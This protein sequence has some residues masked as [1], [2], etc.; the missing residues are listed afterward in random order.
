M[1]Y[2][3]DNK[4]VVAVASS[5]L[6]DLSESHAI[7]EKEGLQ[8]YRAHQQEHQEKPFRPGI[9]FPFIRRLLSLNQ[10]NPVDPPVEVVF[11]SR[12]DPDTGLRVLKSTA[13][14]SLNITR[15]A[16]LNG[17]SPHT[18][19]RALN[20]CLFLSAN[21][22]DVQ[23]AVSEGHP[24]GLVLKGVE[25][26][27]ENDAELRVAFDFDGVLADD[28]AEA[29]YQETNNL[30]AFHAA[31]AQKA[32]LP[33]GSGPLQGLFQKLAGLQTKLAIAK[34]APGQPSVRIAIITARS[35]PAHE[36]V[37]TSLRQWGVQPDETFFLGGIEKRRVLEAFRP[38][39]FF[40]DQVAHLEGSAVFGAMVHV[41]FGIRNAPP[42]PL[43][44]LVS[45]VN[46]E[47][48]EPLGDAISCP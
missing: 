27:V 5:A 16:F 23:Q 39:M 40:D 15:G 37:V 22:S 30:N 43:H 6:F 33:H 44:S 3:I 11:L 10:L 1:P 29:I 38:H 13:H 7:F 42:R 20:V 31:E 45:W 35:A 19:I 25:N 2:C 8:A 21:A 47:T 26:D 9:A 48:G 36:R 24:A 32:T 18:Y 28:E 41:P 46:N 14:Y 34:Q 12:N 17:K 4:L